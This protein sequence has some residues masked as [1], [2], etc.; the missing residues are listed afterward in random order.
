MIS[1]QCLFQLQSSWRSLMCL[2][3]STRLWNCVKII[4]TDFYGPTEYAWKK[5]LLIVQSF[6]CCSSPMLRVKRGAF[7][8]ATGSAETALIPTP[9]TQLSVLFTSYRWYVTGSS[10]NVTK[11]EKVELGYGLTERNF[12]S[13]F[14]RRYLG[15]T[16]PI[17]KLD[18]IHANHT[19]RGG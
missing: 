10:R 19:Q 15:I 8:N 16:I 2:F 4:S 17:K 1:F 5:V 13:I 6:A 12:P 18:L 3:P 11:E 9:K 7:L 14:L